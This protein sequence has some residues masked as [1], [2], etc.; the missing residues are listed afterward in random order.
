MPIVECDIFGGQHAQKKAHL[1]IRRKI[2]R[3][4]STFCATAQKQGIAPI[5]RLNSLFCRVCYREGREDGGSE[6]NS[7][8]IQVKLR[9]IDEPTGHPCIIINSFNLCIN[10]TP[11]LKFEMCAATGYTF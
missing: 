1:Q 7:H 6:G 3:K 9:L 2:F 4:S 5:T 8:E 10:L 11:D